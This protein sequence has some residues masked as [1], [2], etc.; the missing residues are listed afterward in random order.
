MA[1]TT[2]NITNGPS[3][4]D[5]ML[6]FFDNER[7]KRALDFTGTEVAS[8]EPKAYFDYVVVEQFS[9]SPLSLSLTPDP[10]VF[11]LSLQDDKHSYSGTF[12]TKSRQGTFIVTN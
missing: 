11:S 6:A 8:G 1:V 3:R 7:R 10:H 9:L 4:W 12:S 2:L 5:L